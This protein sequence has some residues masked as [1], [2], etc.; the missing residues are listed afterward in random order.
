MLRRIDL[1]KA[2]QIIANSKPLYCPDCRDI[3]A[4]GWCSTCGIDW[5]DGLTERLRAA[6]PQI[7]EVGEGPQ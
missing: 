1:T 2:S 5:C 6:N 4:A 7:Y 3:T